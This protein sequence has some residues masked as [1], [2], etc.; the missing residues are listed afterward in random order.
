[1]DRFHIIDEGAAITLCKGVYRQVKVY[2]RGGKIYAGHA[3]G[4][5]RLYKSGGTSLPHVSWKDIDAP[6]GT[7]REDTFSLDWEPSP[8]VAAE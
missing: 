3:G 4:Y 8:A 1:M 5:I 7:V 6:G 2:Q